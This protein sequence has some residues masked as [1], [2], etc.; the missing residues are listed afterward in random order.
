LK[1]HT[2]RAH[3]SVDA[4][5]RSEELAWRIA[6]VAAD[7]VEVTTRASNG[8]HAYDAGLKDA[9]VDVEI[10]WLPDDAGFQVLQAAY[11]A[12]SAIAVAVMD[13]DIAVA[14]SLGLAGNWK[15]TNFNRNEAL[16]DDVTAN[17]TLK[18]YSYMDEYEVAA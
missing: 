3:R 11:E 17:V 6:E 12:R 14:G 10:R 4:L 16:A 7:E 9:S 13:G 18:P 15:V 1:T 5:P 8:F 2:V